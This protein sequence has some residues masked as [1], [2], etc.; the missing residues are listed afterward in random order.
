MDEE[1]LKA[2]EAK[3]DALEKKV[4]VLEADKQ[5]PLMGSN[6]WVLVPVAAIIMWGLQGLF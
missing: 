5:R 3:V 2:L 1:K 6:V 4:K